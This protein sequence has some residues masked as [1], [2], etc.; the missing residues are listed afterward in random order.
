MKKKDTS[1]EELCRIAA[2]YRSV[3]PNYISL[4]ANH[5][6]YFMWPRIDGDTTVVIP[7]GMGEGVEEDF[8]THYKEIA[9]TAY[10]LGFIRGYIQAQPKNRKF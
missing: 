4:W 3:D 1:F 10:F 2:K 7:S 8:Q 5:D 6:P 9:D